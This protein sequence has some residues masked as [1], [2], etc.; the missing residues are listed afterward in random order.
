V[1]LNGKVIQMYSSQAEAK[2]AAEDLEYNMASSGFPG[3]AP[4]KFQK[5]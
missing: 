5:S 3:D 2:S 1:E 4:V